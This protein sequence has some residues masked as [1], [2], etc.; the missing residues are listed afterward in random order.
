MDLTAA[1]RQAEELDAADPLAHVRERFAVPDDLI[2]LDGNSLGAMGAVL[3]AAMADVVEQQW[4]RDLITSWNA[5]D[6]W[7]APRRVG[8]RIARLVGAGEDEVVVADSTSV[9]LFK[10]LVAAARLRPERRTLVI[11]PGNFPA[12]LYIADSVGELLGLR[13]VRVE[14][15]DVGSVLGDD[16]AVVAFSHVDYGTGR[17][18]DVAGVTRAVHDAG[19]LA[20]WDLSHSAGAL[21]VRLGEWDVDFAVGCTYKYLNGGPGA[22][23]YVMAARRHHATMRSPMTGWTGHARPF[24]ME[25]TYEAAPGIDGMRCGTPPM[26][27]LLAVEAALSA[28]DGLSMAQV[29]ARSLSLTGLFLSLAPMLEPLG[30]RVV[31]PLADHERGSQVSLGHPSAY[32]IVQA[33]IARGVIGDY[34]APDIVRLGL[35]PLYVRHVDVVDAVGHIAAVVEAGEERDP[36]YAVQA[37]VT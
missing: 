1:R 33:L 34:R 35:A 30:F 27:S 31:T 23:A 14:P 2:Y 7:H 15:G 25:G 10:V 17:A 5:H 29:R 18:H 37:T 6:W 21:D 16:V 22:P 9:N 26:L 20:V 3:P 8:G 12:D 4:G 11:E 32:A 28:F 36:A 24:A 13:V 19:A